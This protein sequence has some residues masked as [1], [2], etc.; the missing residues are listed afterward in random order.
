VEFAG[1]VDAA[2]A[3]RASACLLHCADAEP[4]GIVVAE[5]LAAGRPVAAPASYGPA[6]IVDES[7]GRLYEPGD[8]EAAARALVDAVR[9]A[10]ALGQAGRRR[11]ETLFDLKDVRSRYAEVIGHLC[12]HSTVDTRP[13]PPGDGLVL[14]TVTHNSERDVARLLASAAAHLPGA[15]AIVVDSGSSDA[16]AETARRLGAQV[17]ELGENVGFGRASNVG[18][19]AAAEP[20]TVLVNPD[21]ELVDGSLALLADELRS[22]THPERIL[23]PLVLRPDGSRQDS[24][25]SEPAAAAAL[26][27]ALVPPAFM[28]PPLRR[29]A[30]PWTVDRPRRVGWAV[31]CCLAAYTDTLRRLGPNDERSFMYAEDLDLGLR[32]SDAGVE[33]WFRPE[34]RVLHHQAHASERAFG[35]EPF[36]LL[37]LRRREVVAERRGRGRAWLDDTLQLATFADRVALKS[38]AF[39]G[40]ERERAQIRALLRARRGRRS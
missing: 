18:V 15:S 40:T 14:V 28:P 1:P 16:S 17:V 39:R 37:A 10:D 33:T 3:L 7:C 25:Q 29:A 5:A 24:A 31:G 22:P 9:N 34:A 11:A 35:G 6:E 2:N 32:A 8:A 20:V 26:A 23:A 27:I 36:D 30:C 38:L 12:H 19:A 21:V 13:P 4:F